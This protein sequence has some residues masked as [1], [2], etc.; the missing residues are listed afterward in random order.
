VTS[1][2]CKF[3]GLESEPD[4]CCRGWSQAT[5]MQPLRRY[6]DVVERAVALSLERGAWGEPVATKRGDKA[7]REAWVDVDGD[8]WHLGIEE[9][10]SL[11]DGVATFRGMAECEEIGVKVRFSPQLVDLVRGRQ[12]PGAK[13][14]SE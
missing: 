11:A 3:C 2:T 13:G 8:S 10:A 4:H 7:N 5:A 12:Y 14:R 6:R 1:E 9:S